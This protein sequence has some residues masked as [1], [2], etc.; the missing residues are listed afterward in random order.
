MLNIFELAK[1]AYQL[2]NQK[3][4]FDLSDSRNGMTLLTKKNF[5][6]GEFLQKVLFKL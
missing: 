6:F 5:L 1:N 3:N 2:T 4:I